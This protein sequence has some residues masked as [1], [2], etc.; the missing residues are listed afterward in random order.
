VVYFF[1][2]LQPF[3]L[4]FFPLINQQTFPL[5]KLYFLQKLNLWPLNVLLVNLL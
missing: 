4:L 1:I 2:N 5:L 3:T